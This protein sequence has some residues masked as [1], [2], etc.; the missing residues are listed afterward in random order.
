ME[1]DDQ[2][3]EGVLKNDAMKDVDY[4]RHS[5]VLVLSTSFI[6]VVMLFIA[7][8]NEALSGPALISSLT[9]AL[10]TA[11]GPV[12]LVSLFLKVGFE[13]VL[14]RAATKTFKQKYQQIIQSNKSNLEQLYDSLK[15]QIVCCEKH[16]SELLKAAKTLNTLRDLGVYEAFSTRKSAIPRIIEWLRDRNKTRFIF[17]GTSFRGLLWDKEGNKEVLKLIIERINEANVGE[18]SK[19]KPLYIRFIFTHPAFAYLR[20]Q[21]EGHE[22]ELSDTGIREEILSTVLQLRSK[23]VPE[24]WVKFFKGTPTMFGVMTDNEM[25]INPY[26]YKKQSYT[27]FGLIIQRREVMMGYQPLYEQLKKSHFDGV[28]DDKHNIVDWHDNDFED[29]WKKPLDEVSK[30]KSLNDDTMP[31][32]LRDLY[33]ELTKNSNNTAQ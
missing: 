19:N 1:N 7:V 13:P 24:D 11:C 29:L 28:L 26:P 3:T 17:V 12:A 31:Q 5:N 6:F 22:R 27:S 4:R 30:D 18:E 9:I 2:Y 23:G 33:E 10:A 21:A 32:S 20:Q 8:I 15:N 16:S 14:E 25:F